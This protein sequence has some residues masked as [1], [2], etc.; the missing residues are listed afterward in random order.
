MNGP[1]ASRGD[2]VHVRS[3]ASP[4]PPE[5]ASRQKRPRRGRVGERRTTIARLGRALRVA[6]AYPVTTAAAE[7]DLRLL[8]AE[9]GIRD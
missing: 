9:L 4:G 8:R 7:A 1:Q 5:P 6:Y 2:V 3:G